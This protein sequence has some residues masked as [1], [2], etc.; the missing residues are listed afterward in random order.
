MQMPEDWFLTVDGLHY[1]QLEDIA[2]WQEKRRQ[3]YAEAPLSDLL[4]ILELERAIGHRNAKLD[5]LQRIYGA[6]VDAP[7]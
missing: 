5:P 1:L 3:H 6:N 4:R 2:E 7:Y